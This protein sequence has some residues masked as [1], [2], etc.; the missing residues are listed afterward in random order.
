MA[1]FKFKKEERADTETIVD[2]ILLRALLGPSVVTKKEALNIPSVESCIKFIADMVSMLPVKLY[3]DNN[4]KAEE[5]KN[6]P[7][8]RLLNDDTN[9]TL[10]AVQFWRA[11][12]TDY[13]LG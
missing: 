10:D 1:W 8:V 7:R 6:D 2:D 3:K 13:F 12:V 5:I 11:M 9:D 4:G